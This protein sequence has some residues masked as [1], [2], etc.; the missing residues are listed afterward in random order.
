MSAP[1]KLSFSLKKAPQKSSQSAPRSSVLDDGDEDA[2]STSA[3]LGTRASAPASKQVKKKQEEAEGIDPSVFDYD[4]IYDRMKQAERDV[5]R[6]AKEEKQSRKPKYM[7]NF[8]ASAEVRERDRLRAEAKMI[9]RERANEGDEFA[10]K[11]AFVT[12]AY[13][14]QQASLAK[15]EGE[16]RVR[17]ERERKKSGGVAAFHRNMLNAESERRQAAVAALQNHDPTADTSTPPAPPDEDTTDKARARK[18]AAQGLNV[19]L[20]DDQQIVDRRD[21]LQRGLN[22]RKKRKADEPPE[23][24]EPQLSSRAQRSQMMEDELLAKMLGDE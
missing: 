9:Q 3:A 10:D 5:Q 20:N 17:E 8:F 1:A 22:F 23:T 2:E 16:E 19:E 11:E 24:R 7:S 15:A 12:D 4:G 6:T 21:L 14:E 18:A 13:R